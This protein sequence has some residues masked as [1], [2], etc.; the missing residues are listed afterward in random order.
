MTKI[1]KE[2]LKKIRK[3]LTTKISHEDIEWLIKNRP[4]LFPNG[5]NFP[6]SAQ[7]AWKILSNPDAY[8]LDLIGS[9]SE[10]LSY[11]IQDILD[12]VKGKDS[13]GYCFAG[14]LPEDYVFQMADMLSLKTTE[15]T[16]G[17]EVV[18]LILRKI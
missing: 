6:K 13:M 3:L 14:G 7:E 8:G 12:A 11:T 4:G 18:N 17:S 9:T 10:N 2:N 5:P 16:D 15:K 1:R